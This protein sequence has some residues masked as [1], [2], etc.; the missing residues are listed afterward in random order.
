M[1][2]K[3]NENTK[4]CICVIYSFY[5][6]LILIIICLIFLFITISKSKKEPSNRGKYTADEPFNYYTE[7]DFCI[8][9]YESY[10]KLGAFEVFDIHIKRI[11]K[12]CIYVIIILFIEIFLI[13]IQFIINY[14]LN[15][16]N[17]T[18]CGI[19]VYKIFDFLRYANQT[20]TL[21]FFIIASVYYFDSEFGEFKKF[22]KC[23]YLGKNFKTDYD[24]IF[25]VKKFFLVFFIF[26]II[27]Y[28]SL[29]LWSWNVQIY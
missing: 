2:E 22:S 25:D 26:Y 24:F 23:K 20:I 14:K 18:I 19:F 12:F 3:K 9:H 17:Y 15:R 7:G 8:K 6:S 1:E 13:I 29:Q 28:V 21:V 4:K 11:K 10:T 27:T 16:A 5:L